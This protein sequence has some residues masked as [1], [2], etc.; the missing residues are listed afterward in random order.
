MTQHEEATR[1]EYLEEMRKEKEMKD[2]IFDIVNGTSNPH[3][4]TNL[5][6]EEIHR[7]ATKRMKKWI[8]K[9]YPFP[10]HEDPTDGNEADTKDD[11][12]F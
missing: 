3:V 6:M 2:I 9:H 1:D 12:P 10:L 11:L 4:A 8:N 5:I 7:R